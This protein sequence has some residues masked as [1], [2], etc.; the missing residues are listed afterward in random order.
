MLAIILG[1]IFS[2]FMDYFDLHGWTKSIIL[3]FQNER[4]VIYFLAFLV[5]AQCYKLKTFELS[6][7]KKME[8]V[9][10][11][12][13]WIPINIYIG[14][15]I[16][17]LISPNDYLISKSMDILIIRLNFLLSVTYLI[18]TMVIIFKNYIN[19]N[20]KIWEELNSNSYG[21]YI[22]HVIV[23]GIVALVML[24][25]NIPSIIKFFTLTISTFG[26][27]S[28]IIYSYKKLKMTLL[29]KNTKIS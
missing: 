13:G 3:D 7:R 26:I 17:S 16:Y 22:I 6:F 18:Y 8:T 1:L 24:N 10:Q 5:G 15:V 25:T 27:S 29:V 23:M 11:S 19:R 28:L 21:V 2:F 4:I 9:I 12:L 14:G 20:S